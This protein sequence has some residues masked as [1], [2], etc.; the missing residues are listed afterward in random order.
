M[1]VLSTHEWL[2][3]F[4]RGTSTET[5]D[6][7]TRALRTPD[8]GAT[9][10]DEGPLVSKP[11]SAPTTHT[12]RTRHFGG[13]RVL[14]FGKWESRHGYEMQRSNR[15]TLGQ[16]PMKLFW[17][18]SFDGGRSWSAPRWIEPP[19]VGP[20]WEL[21]HPIIELPDRSWA[22]PVATW[23]G[24][25]GELPNGEMSGLLVSADGGATWPRF[26]P[27]FDGRK[28]GFIHWEQSVVVRRD[29]SLIA[30]AWVYD[31]HRRE[32]RPSVFA[33]SRD[34]GRSFGA[35]VATGFLA[36]TCKIIELKSGKIV[37]AYRRHDQPGLWIELATADEGGWRTERR[38]L[39]WGGAVS[40]MAGK[41]SVSEELNQLRFGY[42]SLAELD[43]GS[44]LLAFWG[45]KSDR[46]AIHWLRFS[47][48]AI[49]L[50]RSD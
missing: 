45:T 24:W 50:A 19:L 34:G 25:N 20:T 28:A 21:C 9:W 30:T 11:D 41:A 2:V 42:P 29:R 12:I 22:A 26:V 40:G 18:E 3:T 31:P 47:P 5:L 7:H 48:D 33:L 36:Q 39:L 35:P 15:E 32:T 4:D 38:G 37:A 43:D 14:G 8:G 17:I 49:P 44:V 10:I 6:Y 13:R 16:V 46:S 1:N 27:T 23:R